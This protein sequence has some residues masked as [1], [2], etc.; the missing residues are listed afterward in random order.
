MS[1]TEVLPLVSICQD[2]QTETA[3]ACWDW[4]LE[5]TKACW[6]WVLEM[7]DVTIPGCG[8]G[9]CLRCGQGFWSCFWLGKDA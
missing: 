9:S 8:Q 7:T 4:V 2:F 6:D 5:M 1:D 3:E